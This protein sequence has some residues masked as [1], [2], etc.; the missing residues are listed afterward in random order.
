MSLR[1][2]LGKLQKTPTTAI[3]VFSASRPRAE[4]QAYSLLGQWIAESA[5]PWELR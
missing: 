4:R 5:D 1:I 3:G 2:P